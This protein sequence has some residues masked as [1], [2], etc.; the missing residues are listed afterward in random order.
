MYSSFWKYGEFNN[1]NKPQTRCSLLWG[2]REN[3]E[4][5][6]T[7]FLQSLPKMKLDHEL[8]SINLI[9]EILLNFFSRQFT[10][11]YDIVPTYMKMFPSS[12]G[13][14]NFMAL[15]ISLSYLV[16]PDVHFNDIASENPLNKDPQL[17]RED[18]IK[19]MSDSV[20]TFL[21]TIK[22]SLFDHLTHFSP[23]Y[24]H[25]AVSPNKR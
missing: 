17:S 4:Q 12:T 8:L 18:N 9:S 21:M 3:C 25:F 13:S 5:L 24:V 15:L 10:L 23:S 2:E 22:P 7:F 19:K 1:Y 16:S 6:S 20:H 14:S 11:I